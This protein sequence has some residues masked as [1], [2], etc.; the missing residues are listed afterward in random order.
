MLVKVCVGDLADVT[1]SGY[2]GHFSDTMSPRPPCLPS[3]PKS[4]GRR[5]LHP[6]KPWNERN[7][8]REQKEAADLTVSLPDL[9]SFTS[10]KFHLSIRS[11]Y[12]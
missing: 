10:I 4:C 5:A 3:L 6:F 12:T 11:L 2:D 9:V 1:G 8:S 7:K